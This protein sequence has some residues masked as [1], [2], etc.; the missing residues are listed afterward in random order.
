MEEKILEILEELC[1]DEVVRE[2]LD[3]NLTEEDFCYAKSQSVL[4]GDAIVLLLCRGAARH[5][6]EHWTSGKGS[7]VRHLGQSL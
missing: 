5:L 4:C 7:S 6:R 2:D 3:I 1:G